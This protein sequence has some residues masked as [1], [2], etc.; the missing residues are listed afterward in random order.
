M[1]TV[2]LTGATGTI[3]PRLIT[4]LRE[5]GFAVSVLSRSA[6]TIPNVT[7][8]GWNIGQGRIDPQ[9]VATADHIIHLAGA[10]VADERWS[11]ARKKE[12]LDSRVQSTDLLAETLRT[13]P[14]RVQSFVCSSAIGY[15]GGDTGDRLLTES[16]PPGRDFLATVSRAWEDSAGRVAALG[17]R[18]VRVR[19]GVVLTLAGG[20]LPKLVQ[21]V[22]FNAGA[23]IGSG[24]QYISWIHLDDLCR[25]FVRAVQDNRWTGP[26]NGVAPDPATN[27]RLTRQIAAV[28]D[29]KIL[30]P[31][32]PAFTIR[33][34]F[35]ELAVTVLGSS[36]VANYRVSTETD[37]VYQFADL[38][39]ALTHLLA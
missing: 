9:A 16:S 37:F 24:Q 29:K 19:T 20:A 10:G 38:R 18:T 30:L 21:P 13:V 1:E 6:R 23:P 15:Y 33:L 11:A 31:N 36:R 4:F 22:R 7:T 8:Y 28:L 27:E 34:A 12:I 35:G 26:Y 2:L 32:I 39:Q 14:N 25:L 17:I 5:A 3:G